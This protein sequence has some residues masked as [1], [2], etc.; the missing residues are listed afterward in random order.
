MQGQEADAAVISYGVSYPEYVLR[1]AE[2]IYSVNRLNVAITRARCK[3]VEFLPRPL[4][5]GLSR[6]MVSP[7][8]S[9]GLAF[10]ERLVAETERQAP[11]LTFDLSNGV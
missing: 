11:P 1:E 10:M 9:R 6:V 7:D 5:T 8:A 2:F 3:S 4:L